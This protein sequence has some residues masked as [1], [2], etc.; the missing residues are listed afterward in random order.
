MLVDDRIR[1]RT[2]LQCASCGAHALVKPEDYAELR[3]HV[4][5]WM[6]CEVCGHEWDPAPDPVAGHEQSAWV[7]PQF[8]CPACE[9]AGAEVVHGAELE[10]ESIEVETVE[11]EQCTAPR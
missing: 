4:G 10:V 1:E 7:L 9:G 11:E 5:D 2:R 3:A 6:R 8:R